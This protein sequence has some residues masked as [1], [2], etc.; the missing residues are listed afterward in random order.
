MHKKAFVLTGRWYEIHSHWLSA[1]E[2]E[3]PGMNDITSESFF[4]NRIQ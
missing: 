2:I 3:I 4:V 1:L